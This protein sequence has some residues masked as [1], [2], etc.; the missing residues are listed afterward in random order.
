MT[1]CFS[2]LLCVW[3]H[4]FTA[5]WSWQ[6]PSCDTASTPAPASSDVVNYLIW[7]I[8]QCSS[9]R[10]EDRPLQGL[11]AIWQP[12]R[13]QLTQP[14]NAREGGKPLVTGGPHTTRLLSSGT[15]DT[16]MPG[17]KWMRN[18]LDQTNNSWSLNLWYS[19]FIHPHSSWLV[20]LWPVC[21][22]YFKTSV[23]R[24]VVIHCPSVSNIFCLLTCNEGKKVYVF[25]D[26][27]IKY[28]TNINK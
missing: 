8:S 6:V 11:A 22:Q 9:V 23:K 10:T 13:A 7:I 1:Y 19:S 27:S 21:I 3:L 16:M 15:R 28:T 4:A 14:M 25:L 2:A 17:R 5:G 26:I 24:P 12:G 18:I 20:V